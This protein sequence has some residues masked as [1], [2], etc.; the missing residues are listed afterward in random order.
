MGPGVFLNRAPSSNAISLSSP[1]SATRTGFFWGMTPH[2]HYLFPLG[3]EYDFWHVG[4]SNHQGLWL[5]AL[6][7]SAGEKRLVTF[8]QQDNCHTSPITLAARCKWGLSLPAPAR[9]PLWP[10]VMNKPLISDLLRYVSVLSYHIK[11][12]VVLYWPLFYRCSSQ[13]MNFPLPVQKL[14]ASGIK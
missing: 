8:S 12:L 2:R 14:A 1:S 4:V 13:G 5:P 7:D 3:A 10:R 11:A 9:L 6:E